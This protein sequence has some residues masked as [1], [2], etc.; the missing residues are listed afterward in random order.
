MNY[1]IILPKK[2]NTLIIYNKI[3]ELI[4]KYFIKLIIIHKKI[5]IKYLFRVVL[6]AY[7]Y[8]YNDNF[9]EQLYLNN[10]QDIFSFLVLLLPYYELNNSKDI[11]SLDE[12]F[13]NKDSKSKNLS[14]SYYID[15]IE[16]KTDN[17]YL[18]KYF[19]SVILSILDTFRNIHCTLLPNWINIFPYTMKTYKDSLIYKNFKYQFENNK[20]IY[21]DQLIYDI[22]Q[23]SEQIELNINYNEYFILG[24][25]I[26]YGTV[27]NF[28][29]MDI[30][31]IKWMIFDIN[32]DN[33][34][35]LP[36]IIYLTEKL[37][38]TSISNIPWEKLN[39]KEKEK[40]KIL[41][42]KFYK[43]D[44][45]ENKISI[46]SLVMFYLRWEQDQ[47][48]LYE[49]NISKNCLK[50][51]K[52][53]LDNILEEEKKEETIN[54]NQI[55]DNN[56]KIEECLNIIYPKINFEKIYNY[57]YE[58]IQRFKYTW[59]G[60]ICMDENKNILNEIDYYDKYFNNH[61]DTSFNINLKMREYYYVTPK[62][63]YNFCK[64]L[65]HGNSNNEYIPISK[66]C[67][68]DNI[69]FYI[70]NEFIDR[71]NDINLNWFNI[72]KNI[73]RTYSN[74]FNNNI[75]Y[76]IFSKKSLFV[77]VIFETL[78]YNGMLSYFKYNPKLTD[79]L[80]IPN[81]NTNFKNWEKYILNNIDLS[82]Y[83]NS[84]HTFSNTTLESHGINTINTIKESKWYTNF[85]A[86]WIAQIQLYHHYINNRV[87]FITGATGAGKST[88]SPFLLVY[89]VKII[90]F[91][92]NAKVVCTQPRTQPVK[93]NS[94]QIS[95]SIGLPIIIKKDNKLD[96][97]N[98][99]YKNTKNG[100]GVKQDINYIQYKHK[101][102]S[103][104]DDLYHPCLRLY[105]DGS[106]YNIIKQNY[107]FKKSIKSYTDPNPS[108]LSSNLFDIILVDEAHEHNTYMDMLLTLSK[109]SVYINNE[110]SLGIISAT[111]DD[112][113]IIYR[114]Y[115]EPIDD[116]W[117]APLDIRFLY[118]I[119]ISNKN[120]IDRRIH[121][122]IPFGGMN[123][124][125]TE[126]PSTLVNYPKNIG[127]FTDLKKINTEVIEILKHILSTT[128]IGDIL[129]F[130][131]GE[132]D[133]KKLIK[134]IN[135]ITSSNVLAIPFYSKLDTEILEN[136]V[137][138]IAD[139]E[140]RKKI[141][142]PKNK[143]DI[144]QINYIPNN[145]LLP[146]GTYNRFIIIATNIA[147]ASITINSLEFVIDIGNQK[148]SVY[149]S[150]TNQDYLKIIPIAIPN[151]KQRKG[152]VGRVK[153]GN[154]FYTY[155]RTKLSEKVIYKINIE[156]INSF[157]LD[158][159]TSSTDK[160]INENND[161]YKISN[162]EEILE[163]IRNQYIYLDQNLNSKL[164]NF[165]T[166]TNILKRDAS[167]II[168]PY[169]DGK[170][171]LKTLEDLSGNF[172]IIHPN[173][174]SFERNKETLEIISIKPNYFNKINKAFEIGKSNGMITDNNILSNYGILI[175]NIADFLEFKNSIDY[176]KIIL[177]C[178]T[179][180]ILPEFI[181]QNFIS[182]NSII[183]KNILIFIVYKTTQLNFKTPNYFVGNAD[184]LISSGIIN[185]SLF[186]K[187]SINDIFNELTGELQNYDDIINNKVN[188]LLSEYNFNLL[189]KNF[190]E[191]K[192]LL[193]LFYQIKLKFE[194]INLNSEYI[195]KKE[196]ENIFN[197]I[198]EQKKT[199]VNISDEY[200]NIINNIMLNYID[201]DKFI[202]KNNIIKLNDEL[203]N[204]NK[205]NISENLAKNIINKIN[206]LLNSSSLF[207]NE[208]L[209]KI[210]LSNNKKEINKILMDSFNKL[211]DYDKLC[212]IIIK[213]LP[214]NILIKVP[215]TE[216]YINYYNKDINIIYS[217]E[218]I[219][220]KY[221][222]TKV[223]EDKRNYLIFN[224]DMNDYYELNNI[225]VLSENVVN[226]LDKYFKSVGINLFKKNIIFNNEYAE[227]IYQE[228]KYNNILKK[229]DKIIKYICI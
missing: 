20:F 132:A 192:N 179:F 121:L 73:K 85:G 71:L 97:I 136:I 227:S 139:S 215:F 94:E 145:E 54:E 14:S 78:V 134:E 10:Y 118:E 18:E 113:E 3:K 130:Q 106:L 224:M 112:D 86:N 57:I 101:K 12:L 158:L 64:S 107:L 184:Y 37:E 149:D 84:Y 218:K 212:F 167:K 61:P 181:S 28:L 13:L 222:K 63:I 41:W 216:F 185:S 22:T 80:I 137:K 219:N 165:N 55:Y 102:A 177:D 72:N 114:K 39:E 111:M 30:K 226:I 81:K 127:T 151:Q 153:P 27:Y 140:I 148:I 141:R 67:K 196:F 160:L 199:K 69:S 166:L 207:K 51:L 103:L 180:K 186:N 157:I 191:I 25:P 2:K 44:K 91:N 229:I 225:L 213:N 129:I 161:P 74:S 76:D 35:I 144:T 90:N 40:R 11:I 150:N 68:W 220:N 214:Q 34:K 188:L 208:Y 60:F 223:P 170:Y 8:F 197:K 109:Y 120:N 211:S 4:N 46:K 17:D 123:F 26:L 168:Y 96:T 193:I 16:F 133:I 173:E 48:N 201:S 162:Y 38:I 66:T 47:D 143:Y 122:S 125:V 75:I 32:I 33:K 183:F 100:E 138:K 131:P 92:N 88:V 62:N 194:L 117:K 124:E 152:R 79:N 29:Y 154:I 87:I 171:E 203:K 77:D 50:I 7:L 58:S 24:Y 65:I 9:I 116:N 210:N 82:P 200:L 43:S 178:Y 176:T 209:I 142:Y 202:K 190:I 21:Q 189:S 198:L 172:Y 217:L 108:F 174:D 115:F 175:N 19:S 83:K 228:D 187:F 147:E 45:I 6:T 110:V 99:N 182:H 52:K 56:S 15:H 31:P 5:L 98:E 23:N 1:N 104:T 221:S 70:K 155:D 204:I 169:K 89:A 49:L 53:N 42:E 119:I 105:T 135:L 128:Q 93:D 163:C 59:Y 95:K 195:L 36:N 159:V 206:K 156:N 146:E 205:T 126:Y 164:Y